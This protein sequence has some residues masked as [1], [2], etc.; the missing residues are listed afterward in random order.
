MK[1]L[2]RLADLSAAETRTEPMHNVSG[3]TP[4][5]RRVNRCGALHI[6]G[7]RCDLDVKHEGWHTVYTFGGVF[8][9][10]KDAR[11]T[12]R[13]TQDFSTRTTFLP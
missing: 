13:T 9:W 8:R 5:P 11:E 3:L 10:N 2:R 1:P 7:W 4:L 6:N 12:R